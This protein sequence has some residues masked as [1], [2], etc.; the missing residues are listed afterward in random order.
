MTQCSSDVTVFNPSSLP[1]RSVPNPEPRKF[2]IW[3]S[4]KQPKRHWFRFDFNSGHKTT[5]NAVLY[6][7]CNE[8][9]V[10]SFSSSSSEVSIHTEWNCYNF[11]SLCSNKRGLSLLFRAL[12]KTCWASQSKLE[13]IRITGMFNLNSG[14]C[15]QLEECVAVYLQSSNRL[16]ISKTFVKCRV[17]KL[18]H[19]CWFLL[20]KYTALLWNFHLCQKNA[21]IAVFTWRLFVFVF[22]F[23]EPSA[24]WC[25]T[26]PSQRRHLLNICYRQWTLVWSFNCRSGGCKLTVGAWLPPVKM[27]AWY[28]L[29]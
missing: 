12:A 19:F 20:I 18:L 26:G 25:H 15:S 24:V 22:S 9:S 6:L 21:R 29:H 27:L 23:G 17:Q 5:G 1:D 11:V 10:F 7:M 3:Q 14:Y 28:H 8:E 13:L 16:L 2:L 4:Q